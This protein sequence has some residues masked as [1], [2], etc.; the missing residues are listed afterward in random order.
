[1]I[2]EYPEKCLFCKSRKLEFKPPKEDKKE[3]HVIIGIYS[4][5]I[6]DCE[7]FTKDKD[8]TKYEK[9]LCKKYEIPF[10]QKKREQYYNSDGKHEIKHL[11]TEVH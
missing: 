2:P 5:I 6:E 4:G 1:M 7:V 8:A 10:N 11:I 3:V 9:K